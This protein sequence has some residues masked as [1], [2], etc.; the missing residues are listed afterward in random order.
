MFTEKESDTEPGWI[1]CIQ[2][3]QLR[4]F[5]LIGD[6]RY[7]VPIYQGQ[8][9]SNSVAKYFLRV[10]PQLIRLNLGNV[11]WRYNDALM[12]WTFSKSFFEPDINDVRPDCLTP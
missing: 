3:H 9:I 10:M 5:A 8:R 4:M 6:V 1:K 7:I 12:T 11:G 2:A